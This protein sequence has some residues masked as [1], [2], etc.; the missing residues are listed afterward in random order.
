MRNAFVIA[1]IIFTIYS[2]SFH[3]TGNNSEKPGFKLFKVDNSLKNKG[4]SIT[5][6]G[7]LRTL[8]IYAEFADDTVKSESWPLGKKNPPIWAQN[9]INRSA[10]LS[11]PSDNLTKYFYEMSNGNL[12]LYGE[13]Y[14]KTIIPKY[15]QENYKSIADVNTE[16][17]GR[18]DDEIDFSIYDN[19]A[20]TNDG[21]FI[22]R[23]DGKVDLIF[24]IYR[25]FE[26]RL[27]F[28][29]GW[30]GAAHLYL[31]ENFKTNDGVEISTGRL[32]NGSGIQSRGG[33]NGFNYIKYVLAH[34]FGHMLFG[35]GHIENVTNLALMTGGPVWN[36]SRGM[37]SW[38]KAHL[39]WLEFTDIDTSRNTELLLEDYHT[40]NKA[41]R[42]K[43]S[44]N[45]WFVLENHQKLSSNDW[46]GDKGLYIYRILNPNKFSPQID[47]QCADGNWN[48]NISKDEKLFRTEPNIS[49]KSE[50][51]FRKYSKGKIFA[52]Y[53]P[54]YEDNS[55]WGDKFDAF[56]TEYNNLYSPC[57]NPSSI[58]KSSIDFNVF[59]I[60][61]EEDKI[62]AKFF[63]KEIYS[64]TPPSKPQILSPKIGKENIFLR[65]M[66]NKEPDILEY[67]ILFSSGRSYQTE[68]I[69]KIPANGNSEILTRDIS[70]FLTI[71]SNKYIFAITAED[72]NGNL[73]V[74]SDFIEL[75]YDFRSNNW[76]YQRFEQL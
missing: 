65:W 64:N 66:S 2:C 72:K 49:G 13:V 39:G 55:A 59:V 8:L 36:A 14:P 67:H 53:S 71:K 58:N 23:A 69:Y 18:L 75:R 63:F 12:L 46:S 31:T 37:H 76:N 1:L 57:S 21:K 11:S 15:K 17:I 19:W 28:N 56:D 10:L 32:D 5:S 42:I 20:R 51:E 68:N 73:S 38:E 50:L 25:N 45:E 6:L 44:N 47:V 27:F 16:I 40:Q 22:H 61:T 70:S 29:N 62:R 48:F 9:M 24:I 35:A 43:L 3:N 74:A 41:Y 26:N 54:L 30:T 33:K 60:D 52:C 34:E 4:H 7:E